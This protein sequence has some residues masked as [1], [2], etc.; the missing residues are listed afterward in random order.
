M[1]RVAY[2]TSTCMLPG[3]PETRDDY[4]EHGKQ[5]GPQREACAERG[6]EL[7]EQVWD[8]NAFEPS[9]FDAAVIA[10]TWDYWE[11]K[12][13][14]LA[15][16]ERIERETKLFNPVS[17]VRWNLDKGYLRD[18]EARGAPMVP[19]A[20]VERAD[21]AAIDRAFER[22]GCDEVV[23]KPRVGAG[24]W[25]QE[26]VRRGGPRPTSERLPPEAALI[27]P[28]LPSIVEEGEVSLIFCGGRFS[29]A[30]R[31]LPKSGDYRIQAIF[32]G[33]EVMHE[34]D[35][36]ELDLARRC[37]DAVEGMLLHARVDIVRDLEG[38]LALIE[39]ELVEPYLYPEQAPGG[40]GALGE[41]FAEALRGM[42]TGLTPGVGAS[43]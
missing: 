1:F 34:P 13:A 39:M 25:R 8:D 15:A 12:D 16:L 11:R 21:G 42:L 10:T 31:K 29:H 43:R 26:R 35:A 32:G 19:T 23:V 36:D 41:V 22:F 14:F 6:I 7:V 3:R 27:Q 40:G 18:L 24:A 33:R 30:C 17:V 38:R 20:W 5:F 9:A 4:W 37:L 28:F 2:L